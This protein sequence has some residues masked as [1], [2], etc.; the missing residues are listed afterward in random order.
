MRIF[1]TFKYCSNAFNLVETFVTAI[2]P[3]ICFLIDLND[4]KGA[5]NSFLGYDEN[6]IF[7]NKSNHIKNTISEYY[8]NAIP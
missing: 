8:I 7:N 3:P 1:G 2:K 4:L 5:A 6:V